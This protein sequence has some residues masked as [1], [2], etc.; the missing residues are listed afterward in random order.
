MNTYTTTTNH[1]WI[2]RLRSSFKNVLTG[3]VLILIGLALTFWNEGRAVKRAKALKSGKNSV[4]SVTTESN[5]IP[6]KELVHLS[7]LIGSED[8]LSDEVFEV[9]VD[10]IKLRRDVYHYQWK[11]DKKTKKEKE[12]GGSEKTMTTYDYSKEW[13]HNLIPSSKFNQSEKYVNPG[14]SKYTDQTF[15]GRARIN[16]KLPISEKV[17]SRINNFESLAL[18]PRPNIGTI[19]NIQIGS[20]NQT[21]YY[22]GRTSVSNPEIGDE[23]VT[24]SYVPDGEYSLVGEIAGGQLGTYGANSAQP[25]L[26]VKEGILTS[27][28]MFDAALESNATTTWIFRVLGWILIFFGLYSIASPLVVV[29]DVVPFIGDLLG[30]GVGLFSGI[31]ATF[32][33]LVTAAIGWFTYRP[34]LSIVLL[35]V[36]VGI[37][38][39]AKR[40]R[41]KGA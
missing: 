3:I 19:A 9:S 30:M 34:L 17:I 20:N 36:G 29:A 40:V 38:F 8:V 41:S 27:D 25:I 10:G 37:W 5:N 16:Q 12:L 2:S 24:F 35:V 22:V 11:E 15:V 13:S 23:F 31:G 18:E 26:L 39:G 7:G 32:L 21:G 6:E 4:V 28:E 1:S 14:N 33:F